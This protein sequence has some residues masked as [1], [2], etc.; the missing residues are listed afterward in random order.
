MSHLLVTGDSHSAAVKRGLDLL[1]AEGKVPEG[2]EIDVVGLGGGQHMI[3]SFFEVREGVAFMTHPTFAKRLPVLPVPGADVRGTIYVWCGLFH[4][5]KAWRDR[6]WLDFRPSTL[7]VKGAP[8]SMALVSEVLLDWVKHCLELLQLVRQSG[9]R[10]VVMETPR[11]FRH[12][13][14]LKHIPAEVVI[15][16]DRHLLGVMAR[17]C[18]VRR[19]EVVRIPEHCMDE[20]GFMRLEWR[21]EVETDEHHANREFG[22]LMIQE[23]CAYLREHPTY[24]AFE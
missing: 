20:E 2:F 8:L 6:T 4:F 11:P 15:E 19:L 5:A 10:V 7:A 9:A 17:E 3:E 18:E 1:I 12:H 21:N 23:L 24:I 16:V 13:W 14:A 22:A